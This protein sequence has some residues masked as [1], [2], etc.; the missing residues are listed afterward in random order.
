MTFGE[1]MRKIWNP[2]N[3]KGH[4]SPHEFL[5]A[6]SVE[7]EKKY[8]IGQSADPAQ[9][10]MWFLNHMHMDLA[11]KRNALSIVTKTF[12]GK[13]LMSSEVVKVKVDEHVTEDSYVVK[14]MSTRKIPLL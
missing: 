14:P 11:K 4:V 2:K 1:L 5:Q 9:F 3:F 12:G 10:L 8:K 7:S 6:V 13:V